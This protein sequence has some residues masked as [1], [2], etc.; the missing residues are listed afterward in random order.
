[1]QQT[2]VAWR[3]RL[4]GLLGV[5]F[6]EG[7]T[8]DVLRNGDQIFP[9]MLEAIRSATR[10]IDLLTYVYWKGD[11]AEEFAEALS[12]QARSGVRVRV[13]LDAMGAATMNRAW[14]NQM[15]EAGCVVEWFR[16]PT[17]WKIWENDH[18][19]HR[20]VLICDEEVAFTGG[21][22]IAEEWEGDA[23][24]PAEWRDT[25]VRLRGPAVDG[26]RAAFL[27]NWRETG[28]SLYDLRDRF[29]EQP[30]TGETMVQVV[31]CPAQTGWTDLATLFSVLIIGAEHHIRLTTAYFV[32]DDE[33]CDLLCEAA[34][35]GVQVEVLVPGK[36]ADKRVVQ[37]AGEETYEKLLEEGVVIHSYDRSMLHAKIL[38]VDD[39]VAT[40]GSGNFD[41][42]SMRL[43]EECNVVFLDAGVVA[44]L[45][46]HFQEDV[47]NSTELDL[48][49]WRERGLA[50][51]ALEAATE[52][53][54]HKL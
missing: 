5:P 3:R 18:R 25:H 49:R 44:E 45:D 32:P 36:H 19:T 16:P 50:Q 53:F 28:R 41:Q 33:S 12:K 52:V 4:E 13:L 6:T 37:L 23:R 27:T 22:G 34:R 51:R 31:R 20:K 40:V 54:D 8:V 1:M 35:R 11:I 2:A 48:D 21:V 14:T 30:Q 15:Q 47:S 24:Q 42:R 46:R 38:S 26:L 7:N 10:T 17:T 9:A 29:P 39:A 43:N